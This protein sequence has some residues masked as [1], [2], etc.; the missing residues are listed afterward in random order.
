MSKSLIVQNSTVEGWVSLSAFSVD[1]KSRAMPYDS[2]GF[3]INWIR[4]YSSGSGGL[5]RLLILAHGY[6]D[7]V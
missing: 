6:E 7:V 2:L 3:A 5:D 4:S 1:R